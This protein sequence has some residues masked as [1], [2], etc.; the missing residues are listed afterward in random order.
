MPCSW[1][2][3]TRRLIY[4]KTRLVSSTSIAGFTDHVYFKKNAF[5]ANT[6][7][8]CLGKNASYIQLTAKPIVWLPDDGLAG[9]V[10]GPHA[11][12]LIPANAKVDGMSSHDRFP[13][14]T[15]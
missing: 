7:E 5:S 2:Y 9:R 12:S 3:S 6:T 8:C 11:M 1:R 13:A 4:L 14:Q 15:A 10:P